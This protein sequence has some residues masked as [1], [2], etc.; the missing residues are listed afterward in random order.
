[1][2]VIGALEFWVMP[3]EFRKT[4]AHANGKISLLV[5]ADVRLH[6][7]GLSSTLDRRQNLTVVGRAAD[8]D[9]ALKLLGWTCPDVVVLEMAT[10]DSLEIVRA[11]GHEAPSVK[12][13][14]F[15]V[16]ELDSE[17]LACADAGVAGWVPR[18]GSVDDLVAA[19]ESADREELLC[20]PRMAAKLFRRL[21]SFSRVVPKPQRNS[22][23]TRREREIFALIERGLSNKEIARHLN[24]EVATVKNHVHSILGKLQVTTRGEAA[25]IH[26]DRILT[27]SDR[28]A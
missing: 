27:L 24:I 14:A 15:A 7:E 1:M 16:E 22:P 18:A 13:V 5:V 12:I 28:S 9:A 10:R 25:A 11:I 20:S 19:I 8:R 4:P 21:A 23:L 3:G 6:R 17:I 2:D 26:R